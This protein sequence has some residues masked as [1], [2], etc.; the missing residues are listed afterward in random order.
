MVMGKAKVYWIM[1]ALVLFI[2][3]GSLTAC[4]KKSANQA[5]N[6][7]VQAR[8]VDIITL[9]TDKVSRYSELSGTLMPVEEASLS[10][11]AAGRIVEMAYK[12]GDQVATGAIMA[13][14]DAVEYSL[15]VAQAKTG[16]EKAQVAYQK[17]KDDFARMESL[18]SQ[19]ALSKSAYESAQNG[20]AVAEKDYLLAKEALNLTGAGSESAKNLLRAPVGGTVIARHS[21]VG[22]LVSPSV[23]VYRIGRVDN[24]KVILPVPDREISTWNRGDTVTLSLY[25]KNRP[26]RVARVYPT[27]NQSTGAIGVEITIENSGRDWFPGQVVRAVRAVETK[28]GLFLPAEAVLSR[29]EEKPFVFVAAGDKAVK[30]PVT[31]GELMDNKLEILSGLKEGDRVVIKGAEQLFDGNIIKQAGVAK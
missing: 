11:E 15:Q 27:T 31:V 21:S 24:L 8:P 16:L 3:V 26:G 5:N 22:Q 20:F 18:Y 17:A 4:G 30:T 19:G 9:K 23:P 7:E 10:F 25:G 29:G 2:M 6:G 12:E 13:R 14:L 1:M 28:E